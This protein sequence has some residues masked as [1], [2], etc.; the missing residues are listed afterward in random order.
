MKSK[1]I[2]ISA[3][4]FLAVFN[5]CKKLDQTVFDTPSVGN[6]INTTADISL[7]FAG[8]YGIL[9]HLECYK[10]ECVK[11]MELSADHMSSTTT[12]FALFSQKIYDPSSGPISTVYSRYYSVINN[13]NFLLGKLNT[14]KLDSTYKVRAE[15]ELKFMRAFVYFDLVRLFGQVPLR[16]VSTDINSQFYVSR[17]SVSKVYDLIFE[18]LSTASRNLLTRD[19]APAAGLGYTNK[20]AAQALMSLAY[21]TYGNYQER[22]GS[23]PIN[24]FTNAKNYADSVILSGKY[25]LVNNYADLWDVEK[26]TSNYTSEVI[27]G[28]RFTRDKNASSSASKGSEFASRM[29][30]NS[31]PGV[32]GAAATYN[33]SGS[34][35]NPAGIGSGT[36]KV[37]P[38]FY[39]YC[40]TGDFVG[41]YRSEVTFLTSWQ[42]YNSTT[43]FVTYP[44]IPQTGQSL[45]P[46]S[47]TTSSPTTGQQPYI[48]KYTD[49]K[50]LDAS[51]HENDLYILR[52]SEIYLIKA[53][54]ENELN[55]P[56]GALSSF[57]QLR[58]RARKA[59][60]T[61][62]TT[63]A[64]VVGGL[65]KDQ[66]R[67]KIFDER[68]IE[69]IGE[70]KRWFDLV[71]MKDQNGTGT[72]YQYMFGTYLPTITP[73][74]PVYN[75]TSKIWGGGKTE[76]S[77]IVP[78]NAKFL[79][80]PIPQRERDL[81][82]NLTQNPLYN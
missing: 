50:G 28:L 24:S 41:D 7:A 56:A 17:D 39:E 2:I 25:S 16:T 67:K 36:Y 55:G 82:A 48:R 60:G 23:S 40:K 76:K 73:G 52:L 53:E 42:K 20:G 51:N 21:L 6:S 79:L 80:F 43:V 70:C 27:F 14:I 13:C 29:S 18:D 9:E 46:T 69:F 34:V 15:G 32:T 47:A 3:L 54:A 30:P 12:E 65:T 62:R 45:E 10:K 63:P 8:A 11:M 71:R 35:A 75:S 5:S 1:Y 49:G 72:M 64:D 58:A 77:S 38:W 44:L 66:F 4:F 57:N 26:E 61:A 37:Q 31:M 68:G 81:N 33:T 59:N 19:V 78:Y 74:L 22:N